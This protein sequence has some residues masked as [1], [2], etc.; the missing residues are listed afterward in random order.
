MQSVAMGVYLQTTTHNPTWLGLV[1]MGAWL[2]SLFASPIGGALADRRRRQLII[3]VCNLAMALAATALAVLVLMDRLSPLIAVLLAIVEG[4]ASAA[5]WASWQ[6]LLRDLVSA[7]EVM[8]AVSLSSAQFNL[9][10]VIGPLL[11]GL[12]LALGSPGW[13]F[14]VNA[15]SF[16]FVVVV[17]MGV[18][19]TP[20]QVPPTEHHLWA[21]IRHGA[22]T[23][24]RTAGTRSPIVMV[25]IVAFLLSPF[26]AFVP[27]MAIEIFHSGSTGTSWLVTAQGVGA[28]IAAVW[29]PNVARRT[30][31][32]AVIQ[33]SV[34]VMVLAVVAYGLAPN[35][36]LS[37]LA[38]VVIGGAYIGTLTGLNSTVQLLAPAAERSRILSLYTMSLSL[39]YPFGAFLQSFLVK[40]VGL[41]ETTVA[42]AIITALV[43][44][45][46]R[47]RRPQF[48]TVM[49]ATGN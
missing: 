2:P 40:S 19:S 49:G 33:G 48:F 29:M 17:Y 7:D 5:S 41:R 18:R 30:S 42:S 13:C 28:V 43:V 45:G 31:R 34:L 35:L 14:V 3:Q 38:M 26:I 46:L 6:S 36:W 15:A 16:Y 39:A 20:R 21:Q 37:V 4:F 27:T 22:H 44:G 11:A 12:T 25:A 47:L 1:T 24:W 10:R 32:L 23:A 9:G 8:A